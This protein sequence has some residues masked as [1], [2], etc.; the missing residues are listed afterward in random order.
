MNPN[1]SHL[2]ESKQNE[3]IETVKIIREIGDSAK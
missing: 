3:L 1:L 2:P